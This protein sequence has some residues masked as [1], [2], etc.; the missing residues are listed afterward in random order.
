MN[1]KVKIRCHLAGST[2]FLTGKHSGKDSE[3]S[4]P[5]GCHHGALFG[6]NG[7]LSVVTVK[8]HCASLILAAL[9]L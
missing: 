5:V 9:W 8:N 3:L 4:A 2:Y 1:L 6:S 7:W